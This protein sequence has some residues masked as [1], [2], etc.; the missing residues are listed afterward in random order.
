[1]M[2][3]PTL[4]SQRRAECCSH[5]RLT[6]TCLLALTLLLPILTI[7]TFAALQRSLDTPAPSGRRPGLA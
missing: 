4:S 1:M 7:Q 3:R 2:L 6:L 5:F